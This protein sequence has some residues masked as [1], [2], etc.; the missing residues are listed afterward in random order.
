MPEDL[1]AEV[2]RVFTDPAVQRDVLDKLNAGQDLQY[3]MQ[4][5]SMSAHW[6]L[7]L[8]RE[9]GALNAYF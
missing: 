5:L 1:A 9:C 8:P 6:H 4:T 3:S 2:Q 7:R